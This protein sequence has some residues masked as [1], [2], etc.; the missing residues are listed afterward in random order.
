MNKPAGRY[1]EAVAAQFA[2]SRGERLHL[3]G[4]PPESRAR[5]DNEDAV[6]SGPD[7]ILQTPPSADPFRGNSASAPGER[8]Y[9]GTARGAA[10]SLQDKAAYLGANN[11]AA[12]VWQP[13]T[14]PP[15]AVGSGVADAAQAATA[16]AVEDVGASGIKRPGDPPVIPGLWLVHRLDRRVQPPW[17]PFYRT[18]LCRRRRR[19][20]LRRVSFQP[21]PPA[22]PHHP[23]PRRDTSGVLLLARSLTASRHFSAQF[24]LGGVRKEYVA[25]CWQRQ[26]DSGAGCALEHPIICGGDNDLQPS[27][28]TSSREAHTPLAETQIGCMWAPLAPPGCSLEQ[29]GGPTTSGTGVADC[30]IILRTGHGRSAGVRT[31]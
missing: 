14:S 10:A 21:S 7:R 30:E 15:C 29:V 3:G 17:E 20:A 2:A 5:S 22:P 31:L 26:A 13:L 18:Q 8:E 1:C 12:A 19:P 6:T 28:T 16:A 4:M 23:R 27:S 9:I 11:L 25:L 24:S